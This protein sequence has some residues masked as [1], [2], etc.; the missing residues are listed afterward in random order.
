MKKILKIT[1]L[2]LII[3]VFLFSIIEIVKDRPALIL[4]NL[5]NKNLESKI[6]VLKLK[7]L[8]VIPVGTARLEEL[9]IET[10]E[11]AKVHHLKAVAETLPYFS[12]FFKAKAEADSYVDFKNLYSLKFVQHAQTPGDYD[13]NRKIIYDQRR[14]IM[15]IGETERE[16]L[17]NTQDPLSAIFYIRKQEF[18]VGKEFNVNINTNQKNYLL[19]AK[20]IDY[21][22][23]NISGEKTGIWLLGAEVKRRGKSRR[24]RT[25]VKIWFLDN[26]TKTPILIR[27]MASGGLIKARL[28]DLE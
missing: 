27:V 2:G 8:G 6:V 3:V 26:K 13:Y 4:R 9:G 21:K 22:E 15:K 12:K 20:I 14:K 24:H 16:I 18:E 5:K 19:A 25:S 1:F 11:G 10:L 23:I 17:D 28:I 7:A